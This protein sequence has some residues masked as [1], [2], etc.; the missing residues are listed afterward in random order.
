MKRIAHSFPPNNGIEINEEDCK[1]IE[2]GILIDIDAFCRRNNI[3]YSIAYGTLIGAIRHKGFIPWDDDIDIIMRRDEYERFMKLYH[4]NDYEL[5]EEKDVPNHLHSRV[6]D[7]STHLV[8]SRSMRA[9]KIY[10]AG[11]WVDVFPIDKVPED[12]V[13]YKKIKKKVRR[14]FL[15]Q[16]VGEVKGYNIIHNIAHFFLKPFVN[17]FMKLSQKEIIKYNNTNSSSVA[18]LSLWHTNFPPFP[19][20][21]L[22]DYVD[23]VFEGY[24]FKCI[25]NYDA[26]LRGIYG[27][28]MQK[29]PKEQRVAHHY[30]KAYRKK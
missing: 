20:T 1:R 23:V 3:N 13:R 7:P 19:I 24:T 25:R 22:D 4:S 27:D 18:A 14:L 17:F 11:L 28:Y 21:Y 8:F 29:P 15:L 16:C 2:L 9:N 5:V 10:K 30:Y 26:F 12:I 6:S